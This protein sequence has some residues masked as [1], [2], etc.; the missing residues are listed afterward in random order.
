LDR[1]KFEGQRSVVVNERLQR[2]ENQPYGRAFETIHAALYGEDHP[3]GWPIIGHLTDIEQI[4]LPDVADFFTAHY[5]PANV[6][7]TIVGGLDPTQALDLV[8]RYFGELPGADS[9]PGSLTGQA[10]VTGTRCD[11]L[12]EDAVALSRIYMAW[13]GPPFRDDERRCGELLALAMAGA[14]SSPLYQDL[15]QQGQLA[16]DVT[17]FLLPM[18]LGST[19]LLI[20]T[21]KPDVDVRRLEERMT[22][23]I[24]AAALRP[25]RRQDLERARRQVVTG[26]FEQLQST[27]SI[28][29]LLSQCTTFLDDPGAI[30]SETASFLAK[31]LEDM[32]EFAHTNLS[33]DRCVRLRVVPTGET[34][35]E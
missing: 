23:H 19:F 6:V 30:D 28:A 35:P 1:E 16:Q 12:Q 20:A 7:V 27:E 4:E 5:H 22:E 2:V 11:L 8:S 15:V 25:L 32:M 9:T 10:S 3:Y 26:V 17:A 29:D 24:E 13:T 21:A 14:K 18:E 34:E 33:A 31:D